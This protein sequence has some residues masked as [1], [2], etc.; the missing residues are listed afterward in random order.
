MKIDTE[1]NEL[2]V[3][4]GAEKLLQKQAIDIIQFEYGGCYLD[5]KTTLHQV[6]RYLRSKGYTIYRIASDGL[7]EI[8][9]WHKKL[10][11]FAYSNYLAV[12]NP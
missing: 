7:I 12:K 5:S 11:N 3:L 10:E 2:Y 9:I 6:Y 1:G 4:L 8:P